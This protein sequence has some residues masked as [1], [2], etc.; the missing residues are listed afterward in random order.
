MC[1]KLKVD[2]FATK[3]SCGCSYSFGKW[4]LCDVAKKIKLAYESS[5]KHR[6]AY[7]NHFKEEFKKI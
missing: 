5:F 3:L 1:A 4:Q 6:P 7:D 2:Q